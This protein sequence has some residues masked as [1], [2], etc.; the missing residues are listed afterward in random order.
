MNGRPRKAAATG[1]PRTMTD[2]PSSSITADPAPGAAAAPASQAICADVV[3]DAPDWRRRLPFAESYVAEVVGTTLDRATKG[4][5]D[6]AEETPFEVAVLLTSD[7]QMRALNRQFRGQD[8]AT[9]VLAFPQA[10]ATQPA[11]GQQ[12]PGRFLGDVAVGF[13]TV[14]R[15]AE[16]ARIPLEHHLAH[17]IVHG[18]LHLLGHTH[19]G[20]R[21]SDA[22]E[23][24]E[25]DILFDL[26]I[27]DPYA[28]RDRRK[29]NE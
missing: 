21:D 29:G 15:E 17:M 26:G 20:V 14:E 3:L 24:L 5:E 16:D 28:D 18:C 10:K 19:D 25:S 11:N 13:E 22:M 6:S 12:A 1:I 8:Q 9:N 2:D 4:Q 23:G 7:E 27:H